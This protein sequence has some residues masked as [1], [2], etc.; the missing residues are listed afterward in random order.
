MRITQLD[1]DGIGSPNGLATRILEIE[2]D[3]KIPVPISD[4]A[5][6][7]GISEIG[8]LES[9][10]FLGSLLTDEV[11]SFGLVLTKKG[12]DKK[13]KRFTIGHELGH[14]LIPL[15]RPAKDG[16]FLC[17]AS[18]M[19]QWSLREQDRAKRMESEANEF[20]ALILMPP[21]LLRKFF[22]QWLDPDLSHMLATH[23]HFDVSKEAASRAY[24][25]YQGTKIALMIAKGGKLL[26]IY[27]SSTLP[28]LC[29]S[30][31]DPVPAAS[32]YRSFRGEVGS[33][34]DLRRADAGQWLASEWG[35]RLPPVYEQILIQ[36]NGFAT[37]MLWCDE[38]DQDDDFDPDADRTA[39]QRYQK[40][41]ESYSGYF[42]R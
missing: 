11:R 4:L 23:E 20:S 10:G 22:K 36:Q 14:F 35:T 42:R 32:F 38:K 37:I 33:V 28:R 31:G 34:S 7:L 30:R 21:P 6:S 24:A 13:R 3:I 2:P 29:V 8:E 19:L 40:Q 16:Q 12:I 27:R 15:H 41:Q 25:R 18:D 39:K 9:D 17:S 5:L 26:R 1:L